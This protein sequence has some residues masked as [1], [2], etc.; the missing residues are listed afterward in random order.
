MQH[1]ISALLILNDL[2][3]VLIATG[4]L[5]LAYIIFS[6]IGF[7]SALIASAPLAGVIPVARVVPLLAVLDFFSSVTRAWKARHLIAPNEL[8]RLIPGML[9]GQLLGVL[10]LSRL[11][12]TLMAILLGCFIAWYGVRGL[13]GHWS[14]VAPVSAG[15]GAVV[16][17]VAG[18]F[19]G[20]LFGSGGFMY[21]SYLERRLEDRNAFRATQAVLIGLSA[22]WRVSLYTATGLIDR[23][24]MTTALVLLPVALIGGELGKRIDLRLSR[25]QIY[26]ILNVLLVISG[27]VLILRFLR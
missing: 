11:P 1:S 20:G 8:K 24:L 14:S 17:G 16:H 21:A 3:S 10:L 26:L 23:R 19:F 13:I 5:V 7:G 9:L 27:V 12:A 22:A 4:S 15:A 18:G 2:P 25:E 6:L